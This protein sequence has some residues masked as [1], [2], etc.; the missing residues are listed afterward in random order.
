M[1]ENKITILRDLLRILTPEEIDELTTVS[2][3]SSRVSLTDV[4]ENYF[5]GVD[6]LSE[7]YE[8]KE[9]I[10]TSNVIPL[11]SKTSKV[12]VEKKIES[13]Q[14]EEE[15]IKQ[16]KEKSDA[17]KEKKDPLFFD[18]EDVV[19]EEKVDA[20]VFILEEQRKSK[21]SLKKMKQ[22]EIFSLYRSNA[23]VAIDQEKKFKNDLSKST[24]VGV[25]VNK[26]QS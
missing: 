18:E 5:N 9:D 17:K 21:D 13:P 12:I 4:I 22:K 1:E 20:T 11:N 2:A 25:L 19:I 24:N 6:I 16:K 10:D 23:A 26:K 15:G 7:N 3:S 14:V 8:A